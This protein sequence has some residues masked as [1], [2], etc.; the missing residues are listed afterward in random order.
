MTELALGFKP[1]T[2]WAIAVLVAG[3]ARSPRVLARERIE[4]IP[5]ELERFAYHQA[6]AAEMSVDVAARSIAEIEDGVD[7]ATTAAVKELASAAAAHGTLVAAGIVGHPAEVPPLDKVLASHTLLHTAEGE[8]YRSALE[9]AAADAG[10]VVVPAAPKRTVEE[11]AVALGVDAPG[12][13]DRLKALRKELGAPWAADH[14]DATAAAL[15]A[16]QSR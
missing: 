7:I 4:L 10:L 12:L 5:D 14:R 9:E 8:L 3:D 16:L 15:L 13:V 6:Q 1:H 2:G 11:T